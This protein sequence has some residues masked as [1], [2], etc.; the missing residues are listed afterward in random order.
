MCFAAIAWFGLRM[1]IEDERSRWESTA[2]L[3]CVACACQMNGLVPW[4]QATAEDV[5]THCHHALGY[6]ARFVN[7]YIYRSEAYLVLGDHRAAWN[8]YRT[9][10]ALLREQ[11]DADD[12]QM[13]AWLHQDLQAGRQQRFD[14]RP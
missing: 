6:D 4:D 5:R 8:D 13:L 9:A 10:A 14:L 2:K 12:E 1:W 7:G 11:P 3:R